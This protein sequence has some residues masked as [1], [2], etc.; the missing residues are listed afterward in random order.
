MAY[1]KYMSKTE[2][3]TMNSKYPEWVT[4]RVK[5]CNCGC[6]GK[7]PHHRKSFKRTI[8]NIFPVFGN[9]KTYDG[10]NI[11]FDAIGQVLMGKNTRTVARMVWDH[12]GK[13]IELGW[14]IIGF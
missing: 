10:D 9:G 14:H 12:E 1:N 8:K 4:L 6:M 13:R 11:Q 3:K 2:G 5:P 7:D